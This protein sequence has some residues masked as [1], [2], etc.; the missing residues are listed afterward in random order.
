MS[1]VCLMDESRLLYEIGSVDRKCRQCPRH[2]VYE[3][4]SLGKKLDCT[5]F[6]VDQLSL[7][8][9]KTSLCWSVLAAKT[10]FP[11]SR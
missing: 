5:S 10:A 7:M 3:E 11:S 8:K 2:N 4:I 9:G 6:Y 1:S